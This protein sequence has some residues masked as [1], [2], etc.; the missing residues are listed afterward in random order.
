MQIA[1]RALSRQFNVVPRTTCNDFKS[2]RIY[3]R[4]YPAFAPDTPGKSHQ[5]G[6][7]PKLWGE[8]I[9]KVLRCYIIR[10][11]TCAIEIAAIYLDFSETDS[12]RPVSLW[13]LILDAGY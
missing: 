13:N 10:P 3:L 1:E 4:N 12:R 11:V 7:N 5:V 2:R 9:A 8:K 6:I